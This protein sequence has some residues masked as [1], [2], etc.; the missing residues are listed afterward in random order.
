MKTNRHSRSSI[1]GLYTPIEESKNR[2]ILPKMKKPIIP[3]S[4]YKLDKQG[5]KTKSGF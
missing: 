4:N 5:S 2:L 3:T 1:E